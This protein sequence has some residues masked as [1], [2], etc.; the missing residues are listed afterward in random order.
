VDF[1][2]QYI[3]DFI[4]ATDDKLFKH[5]PSK[6]LA[7]VRDSVDRILEQYRHRMG[8]L[9]ANDGLKPLIPSWTPE[10]RSDDE[11]VFSDSIALLAVPEVRSLPSLLL[12]E[13]GAE[14]IIMN[15]RQAE[16][17]AKVFSLGRHVCADSYDFFRLA[18]LNHTESSSIPLV[19][20]RLA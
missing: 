2:I 12:H 10:A 6:P 7:E 19:L 15:E 5:T 3:L 4:G 17:I 20:V 1:Y 14:Q 8:E 13:L 11:T 18:D 16:Y 9:F